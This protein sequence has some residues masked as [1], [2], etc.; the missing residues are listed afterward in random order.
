MLKTFL[1]FGFDYN[2]WFLILENQASQ[3]MKTSTLQKMRSY[4]KKLDLTTRNLYLCSPPG[5]CHPNYIIM[6]IPP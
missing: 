1:I 2:Y 3:T 5:Y 4:N 6:F